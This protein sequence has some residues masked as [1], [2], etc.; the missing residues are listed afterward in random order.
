MKEAITQGT[1]GV[2]AVGGGITASLSQIEPW[3]RLFSLLVG[4]FIGGLSAYSI[5]LTIQRKRQKLKEEKNTRQDMKGKLS[6][7]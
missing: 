6:P 7:P 1:V 4:I 3:L 2:M 5:L